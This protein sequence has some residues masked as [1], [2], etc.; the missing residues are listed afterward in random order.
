M[1]FSDSAVFCV[2]CGY[3]NDSAG[4]SGLFIYHDDVL[5][6]TRMPLTLEA[7]LDG[8]RAMVD[9][10]KNLTLITFDIK[11]PAA[12]AEFGDKLLHAVRTH[13]NHSGV[14]VNVIFSVGTLDDKEVFDTILPEL[15]DREGVMVDAENSPPEVLNYF[16][17]TIDALNNAPGA[18]R[19]VP[20]NIGYGN[21]AMGEFEGLAP[22]VLLSIE[23][24][25]WIRAG[26]GLQFAIPYAFPIQS[27]ERTKEYMTA[28]TD[29]LIPNV[30]TLINPFPSTSETQAAISLLAG[31]VTAS[32]D[33]YLATVADDP[34]KPSL[35]A[36][37]LRVETRNDSGAGTDSRLTFTLKGCRGQASVTYDASYQGR[38]ESGNVNY[39][40]I[41][42]KDLG[43][44]LSLKLS[45]DGSGAGDAWD[46]GV[47]KISSAKY[48]IPH[49]GV[50]VTFS[51]TVDEDEPLTE[52]VAPGSGT[53]CD[54]TPPVA[55]PSKSPPAS[56]AG[57]HKSDVT[58]SWNWSD[59]GGSGID[60][61][62]CTTSS[63]S[64][65]VGAAIELTASCADNQG[66]VGSAS[67]TVSVESTPPVA[68]P[69]KSPAADADGW[70][71]G[72]VTVIWNWSD[73]GGSGIDPANCTTSSTSS[74]QGES[75]VVSATC[76]DGAGNV[77]TA[78]TTVNVDKKRIVRRSGD[79]RHGPDL[80]GT[81]HSAL[82]FT[83]S[84]G[85]AGD[86]WI[87]VYDETA[88]APGSTILGGTVQ[89]SADVLVHRPNNK[90][91]AGLLALYNEGAG[92]K[93]L[94]LIVYD[95]GNTD[96]LVL[97]TVDQAGKLA[98]ITSVSLGSGIALNQWYRVT[99]NVEVTAP[100]FTVTGKVYKHLTPNDPDSA[101]G[102]QVGAVL[103]LG[104]TSLGSKGLQAAGQVGVVASA[105]GAVVDSSVTNFAVAP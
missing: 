62:N 93:G 11:S 32:S 44:L 54:D 104:P 15:G 16:L 85:A 52:N 36:Y 10:G 48:N 67:I 95:N 91:G 57:W 80:G 51:G 81:G 74:G 72:N 65:G 22:N 23:Q 70:N 79:I 99:M 71:D 29:G 101:V 20:Y 33:V 60:P 39:V 34:F 1:K 6:T 21:G 64:S 73:A 94:V 43:E 35:E 68:A 7:Y 13:L 17:A 37:A 87:T 98:P 84:A 82:N 5:V 8:L 58:V 76:S 69:S 42:S 25:A 26:Q 63:T 18:T 47:I 24:A 56:A 105:I 55:A 31:L 14:H 92:Q 103:S 3:I 100:N 12:K 2:G 75:I 86:T 78:S 45:S 27:L 102:A 59:A 19:V 4:P 83:G 53:P 96:T 38:F 90:K 88:N 66:N 50:S 9:A 49:P 61:A 46:P 40:T 30:N 97:A 41:P 89:L 28:G 77:G